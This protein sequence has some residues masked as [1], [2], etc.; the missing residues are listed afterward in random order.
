MSQIHIVADSPLHVVKEWVDRFNAALAAGDPQHFAALFCEESYWRDLLALTWDIRTFTG[1]DLIAA[2][3]PGLLANNGVTP[4]EL[5][6]RA[7]RIEKL[8]PFSETIGAFFRFNTNDG[9]CR[10]FVR[11]MADSLAG[12]PK[13]LTLLSSLQ[14][15]INVE[16]RPTTRAATVDPE[17]LIIGAGHAGLSLAARLT[18]MGISTVITERNQKVGDNWRNRYSSLRL[19]NQLFSCHLPNLP[20]P[21]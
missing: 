4:L 17:V 11:I 13:A 1:R 2:S 3:L 12:T 10:G 16:A 15:L 6:E 18:E 5:E 9:R 7:L 20:F 21:S 19:H 14:R 8:E